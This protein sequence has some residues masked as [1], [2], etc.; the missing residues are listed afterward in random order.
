MGTFLNDKW[1]PYI[2]KTQTE[3]ITQYNSFSY[4][5]LSYTYKLHYYSMSLQILYQAVHD[6]IILRLNYLLKVCI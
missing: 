4:S 1:P 3:V 5:Q 6:T 2:C